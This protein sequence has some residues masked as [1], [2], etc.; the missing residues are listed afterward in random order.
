[1]MIMTQ[2]IAA[3]NHVKRAGGFS[4]SDLKSYA[5]V[6]TSIVVLACGRSNRTVLTADNVVAAESL[7]AGN[8]ID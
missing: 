5:T 2:T 6:M 4:G 7:R 1:M 8:L 3:D